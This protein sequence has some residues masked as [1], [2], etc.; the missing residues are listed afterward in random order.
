[1]IGLG[2]RLLPRLWVEP[3]LVGRDHA[4]WHLL[5]AVQ[6]RDD[7]AALP[8]GDARLALDLVAH[9]EAQRVDLALDVLRRG[10]ARIKAL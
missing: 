8:L 7:L 5:V 2:R 3:H 6:E 4:R 10:E 9:G 1:L